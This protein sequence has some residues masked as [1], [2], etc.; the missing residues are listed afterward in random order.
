MMMKMLTRTCKI[1]YPLF[2][3]MNSLLLMIRSCTSSI[4]VEADDG[5]IPVGTAGG[6]EPMDLVSKLHFWW[7]A[8]FTGRRG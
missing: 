8:Y 2:V 5:N 3:F 7:N 6:Y 4:I 1:L